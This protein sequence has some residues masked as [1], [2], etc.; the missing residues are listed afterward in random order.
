MATC[1]SH[2]AEG[3][4]DPER[5][6]RHVQAADE[7]HSRGGE[8]AT[9]GGGQE[10][11]EPQLGDPEERELGDL[12]R[13]RFGQ[14]RKW[15]RHE[16]A[17]QRGQRRDRQRGRTARPPDADDHQRHQD[18]HP[19]SEEVTVEVPREV[20][21]AEHREQA[22]EREDAAQERDPRGGFAEDQLARYRPAVGRR[23]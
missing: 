1:P 21:A 17:G 11:P 22:G 7:R 3:Q 2:L 14:A 4:P 9:A 15:C 12:R 6:E 23:A 5:R 13:A 20:R 16:A 18:G 8:S 19:E 10:Q